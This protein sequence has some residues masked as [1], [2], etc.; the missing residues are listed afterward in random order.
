[1]VKQ[2]DNNETTPISAEALYKHYQRNRPVE[3]QTRKS[4]VDLNT[5]TDSSSDADSAF[6]ENLYSHYQA[7]RT[8]D[9]PGSVDAIMRKVNE[10]AISRVVSQEEQ[11]SLSPDAPQIHAIDAKPVPGDDI[12][13]DAPAANSSSIWNRWLLPGVAAAILGV[14]LIPMLMTTGSDPD[15]LQATVPSALHDRAAQSVAYIEA[16]ASGSFGFADTTN[17]AQIA[18]NNGVITTDLELLVEADQS[19]KIRTFLRTLVADQKL[20]Q[21]SSAPTGTEE[22]SRK[23]QSSAVSMNDAISAGESKAVLH[24]HLVTISAALENIAQK[25]EQLDWYIAGRSVESI[26]VAAEYT[27]EHSD[28]KPLEEALL[29][30]NKI[31]QPSSEAPASGLLP[32]LLQ[33]DL[34]GPEEFEKASELLS[35]ANDIKLLMQ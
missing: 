3:T 7:N 1:M 20:V 34:S 28:V 26:R 29:F 2:S 5:S 30:S 14:V 11:P 19:A 27:L 35:K 32:E 24:E 33:A 23:V 22:L 15:G 25:T 10:Q 18:F 13:V 17:A 9:T 12:Q 21:Q 31:T 8:S 6:A 4:D 16:P